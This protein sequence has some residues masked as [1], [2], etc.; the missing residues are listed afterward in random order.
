MDI[1][2]QM[3]GRPAPG[4][5]TVATLYHVFQEARRS[6]LS[7]RELLAATGIANESL[8]DFRQRVSAEQLFHAWEQVMRRVRDPAFP[9]R[10]ARHAA[11]DLRSPVAHLAMASRTV[12]EA[13]E[14]TIEFGAAFT[15]AYAFR[16]QPW[17]DG[18]SV[19]VEGLGSTRLGERCE[20]EF[21][22]ADFVAIGRAAVGRALGLQRVTFAHPAPRSVALHRR[23]FGPGLQFG[24]AR[25]ELTVS[26][27]ALSLPLR[28]P[29]P[30]LA[31]FLESA[32]ERSGRPVAASYSLRARTAL[33]ER[34][35]EGE[36]TV[37]H[38]ARRLNLSARTLHRRLGEEGVAFR[39]V[40]DE[41]R[42]TL[43]VELLARPELSTAAVAERLGFSSA[44]SFH[45]AFARWTDTSPRGRRRGDRGRT[46]RAAGPG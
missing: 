18:L 14:R 22:L 32:L 30:G 39:Q 11:A 16:L 42:H 26:A 2:R 23:H 21:G 9:V 28:R 24:G 44:R 3:A 34:L 38:V 13:L 20:A 36:V 1:S 35:S 19:V 10:A 7:E 6:G 33:V 17:P 5:H 8:R 43:A 29:R 27:A 40:L 31:A 4:T 25:T 15:T 37:E 45:R 41:T 46:P 12:R